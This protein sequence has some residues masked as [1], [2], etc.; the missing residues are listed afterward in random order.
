MEPFG[1]KM[2]LPSS[3][4]GLRQVPNGLENVFHLWQALMFLQSLMASTYVF[5]IMT[6]TMLPLVPANLTASLD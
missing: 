5:T 1:S 4:M 2:E 6:N 3:K